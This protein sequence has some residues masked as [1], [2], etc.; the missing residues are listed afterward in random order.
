MSHAGFDSQEWR[1]QQIAVRRGTA[2]D[3]WVRGSVEWAEFEVHDSSG[4]EKEECVSAEHVVKG[5]QL[6]VVRSQ[7]KFSRWAPAISLETPAV[8]PWH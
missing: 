8:A 6:L 4:M 1:T 2:F 7:R 5:E 3:T